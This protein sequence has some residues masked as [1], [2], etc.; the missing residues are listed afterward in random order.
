[1]ATTS[2]RHST[3]VWHQV[4]VL[5]LALGV[6]L[7]GV[8]IQ[9]LVQAVAPSTCVCAEQGYCPRNPDGDCA[10][11]QHGHGHHGSES[12][13]SAGH[14]S[15]SHSSTNALSK[16][17]APDGSQLVLRSCDTAGPDARA[18]LAATKWFVPRTER[19]LRPPVVERERSAT[20][21]AW[22]PQRVGVDIFHPPRSRSV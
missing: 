1:M 16:S 21:E 6:G 20:A 14:G 19:A 9:S 17:S 7:Q 10:C 8:P 18:G 12:H 3:A 22:A 5:V 11:S 4:L 15:S 2:V 13:A